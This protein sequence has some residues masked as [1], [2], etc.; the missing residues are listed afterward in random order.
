M[1]MLNIACGDRYCEGWINI[2]FHADS[3]S[4]TKVNILGGLPFEDN[5]IDVIYSSHFLEHLSPVQAKFVLLETRRVLKSGGIIR[6]SVPDL[7][8]ICVEYLKLLEEASQNRSLQSKYDFIVIELLDQ[9]V[10]VNSGGEMARFFDLVVDSKNIE[11]ANYVLYRTGDELLNVGNL[12]KNNGI[13]L[14]KVK[15]KIL[16]F[17]LSVIRFLIPKNLRSLVLTNTSIGEKHQWMYDR[18]SMT[19]LLEGIGF[20]N[21]VIKSYDKSDIKEFDSYLLDMKE[22]G[23]PYKGVSSLYIEAYK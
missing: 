23:T 6:V 18:L 19:N 14:A 3:N 20:N 15:N 9:L 22:D 17:Y 7:E 4:V 21:V 16:Y 5:S 13:T 8:N 10:R 2:D 12:K 11:L 1:K